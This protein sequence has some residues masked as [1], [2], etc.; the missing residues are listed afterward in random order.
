M[1]LDYISI[2]N[3]FNAA[4]INKNLFNL[5]LCISDSSFI[6]LNKIWKHSM[7][8]DWK[9]KRFP[10][11]DLVWKKSLYICFQKF[12]GDK[13]GVQSVFQGVFFNYGRAFQKAIWEK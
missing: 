13:S 4:N 8:K 2:N 11:I 5:K 6:I 1:N 7:Y 9:N 12:E 3:L 10:K